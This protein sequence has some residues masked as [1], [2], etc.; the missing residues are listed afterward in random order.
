MMFPGQTHFCTIDWLNKLIRWEFV[1]HGGING[2]WRFVVFLKC[3]TAFSKAIEDTEF[4]VHSEV[5]TFIVSMRG[6]NSGSHMQSSSVCNQRIVRLHRNTI[7]CCLCHFYTVLYFMENKGI[8]D[9]YGCVLPSV[10][11]S[12]TIEQSIREIL[13]RLEPPW[14]MNRT[15]PMFLPAQS[16]SSCQSH[17]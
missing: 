4:H 3:A 9:W 2:Y 17:S 5:G 15:E 8:L 14:C 7:R 12:S 1:I 13:T 11:V 16:T 10:C 6:Q